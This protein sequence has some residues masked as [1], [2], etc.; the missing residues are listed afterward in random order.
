MKELD[1]N[2]RKIL[3]CALLVVN[4]IMINCLF[5]ILSGPDEIKI[6]ERI[7]GLYIVWSLVY[8]VQLK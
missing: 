7:W 8:Y 1:P 2:K 4:L 6:L 5:S 3:K